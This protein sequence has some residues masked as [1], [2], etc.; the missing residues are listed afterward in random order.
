MEPGREGERV[1]GPVVRREIDGLAFVI[2][3]V[4]RYRGDRV[5]MALALALVQGKTRIAVRALKLFT[6]ETTLN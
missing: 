6:I 2:D 5:M 3:L 4:N 1:N